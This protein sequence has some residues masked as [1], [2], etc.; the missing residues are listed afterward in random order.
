M[1]IPSSVSNISLL[2]GTNNL[3]SHSPATI[4]STLT[5]NLFFTATKVS[6]CTYT[7]I[8]DPILPRF[9]HLQTHVAATYS[10]I[11]FFSSGVVS[12]ICFFHEL[13]S[14]LF[15]QNLYRPDKLHLTAKG[16]DI[17]V[18]WFHHCLTTCTETKLQ[19]NTLPMPSLQDVSS[20]LVITNTDWPPLPAPS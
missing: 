15:N 4:F 12:R 10:C 20:A 16:N 11:L 14:T 2:F 13:Q 1:N 17:L 5:E 19:P 18:K 9:G 3:C 8:S 7:F 6:Y